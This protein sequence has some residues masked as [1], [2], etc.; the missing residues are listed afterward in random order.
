MHRLKLKVTKFNF[1]SIVSTID[2]FF[3]NKKEI[4]VPLTIRSKSNPFMK[5]IQVENFYLISR[6]TDRLKIQ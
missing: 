6:W 4:S 3:Y 2:S 1:R 5:F